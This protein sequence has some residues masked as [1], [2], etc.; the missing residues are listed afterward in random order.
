MSPSLGAKRFEARHYDFARGVIGGVSDRAKRPNWLKRSDNLIGRPHGAIGSVR[1]GYR[2]IQQSSFD[3]EPTTLGKLVPGT[4]LTN[5]LLVHTKDAAVPGAGKLFSITPAVNGR[6]QLTPPFSISDADDTMRQI[7]Q[8]L[9]IAQQGGTNPPLMYLVDGGVYMLNTT[10][11]RP[12]TGFTPGTAISAF[13]GGVDVGRHWYRLR[14]RYRNGASKSTA[15]FPA[16]GLNVTAT[17]EKVTVSG[18]LT[19][20]TALAAQDWIGWTLERTT[21]ATVTLALYTGTLGVDA[22]PDARAQWYWV[23]EGTAATYDDIFKDADLFFVT[24]EAIYGDPPHME[25]IVGFR[26]RLIGWSGSL[27]YVSQAIGDELGSGI[28]N[29]DPELAYRIGEDNDSIQTAVLQGDRLV[30]VKTRTFHPFEGLGPDDFRTYQLPGTGGAVGPRA[31]TVHGT[32]VLALGDTGL[33]ILRGNKADPWGETEVGHYLDE[34]NQIATVR[35]KVKAFVVAGEYISFAYPSANSAYND[36]EII[37]DLQVREFRHFTKRRIRDAIVQEDN[38]ADFN[39]ATL[40]TLDHA[41]TAPPTDITSNN[42]SFIVYNDGAALNQCRAQKID[43]L[44]APQWGVNGALIGAASVSSNS[45]HVC[46]DGGTGCIVAFAEDRGAGLATGI[47]AQ[48]LD[49]AGAKQWGASGVTINNDAGEQRYVRCVADGV[50]GAYIALLDSNLSPAR[51]RIYRINSAGSVVA[52]WPVTI[53][54]AANQDA[55]V[56]LLLLDPYSGDLLV[57]WWHFNGS[58]YTMY[59]QR[60]SGAGVAAWTAGGVSLGVDVAEMTASGYAPPAVPD[61][62]GGIIAFRA[63]TTSSLVAMRI[64]AAGST[65]WTSANLAA[66]LTTSFS[67]TSAVRDGAGGGILLFRNGSGTTATFHASRVNISGTIIWG[68]TLVMAAS[69]GNKGNTFAVEDGLGGMIAALMHDPAGGSN[70]DLY[71]QRIGQAGGIVWG[72][73]API[74]VVAATLDQKRPRMASD[75]AG[76]ALIFWDDARAALQVYGQRLEGTL[77]AAQWA[78][79]GLVITPDK[80]NF[81]RGL[82]AVFTGTPEGSYPAAGASVYRLW[83]HPVGKRDEVLADGTGGRKIPT[84]SA[85]PMLDGGLPDIVKHVTRVQVDAEGDDVD[86]SATFTIDPGDGTGERV[87]SAPLLI[88]SEGT[89]LGDESGSIGPTDAQVAN[90]DGSASGITG[91]DVIAGES[92][93]RPFTGLGGGL[94]GTRYSLEVR[95]DTDGDFQVNGF[96]LDGALMPKRDYS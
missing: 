96:T 9:F 32:D 74:V 53:S 58:N 75:G 49:S 73:G 10:I 82:S 91:L 65:A 23:A 37:F 81:T 84:R 25:G 72:G 61:M 59:V 77:G 63:P 22:V 2:E 28:C 3:D 85:T 20:A 54:T 46:P 1:G 68:P 67:S 12:P 31:V 13:T 62:A 56:P 66:G 40:L 16:G 71:A 15:A 29:F 55:D 8:T 76:G 88:K 80:A 57:C 18:L 34:M 52:G 89:I 43:R 93:L 27:L 44:G 21:L 36:E 11:L 42:P 41:T 51:I 90:E 79:N 39:G 14:Y 64:T 50:G 4:G 69:G 70:F 5:R 6:T 17:N 60:Y 47:F 7:N 35:A 45:C 48:R 87:L 38:S 92:T 94:F 83:A 24:D 19:D 86:I 30:V 95:A 33:I 26:D 78:A